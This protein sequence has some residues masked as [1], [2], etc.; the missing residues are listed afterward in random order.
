MKAFNKDVVRTILSSKKRFFSIMA[1]C[2]L[3]VTM[4]VGLAVACIDLRKSA[5]AFFDGQGL[6]DLSVTSTLGLT[7]DDV[8]ALEALDG[9]EAAEGGY[10]A[11]VHTDIDG[12][13]EQADVK[14]LSDAGINEPYVLEGRLPQDATEVAVTQA[15]LND[16]GKQIGDTLTFTVDD[17]SQG[18]DGEGE[19]SDDEGTEP[20]FPDGATYTI[21]GAVVDPTNVISPE[22]ATS[23]RNS[24]TS[25]YVFYLVRDAASSDVYSV[26]YLRVSG[27][28]EPACYSGAY[29]G[30]VEAAQDEVVSIQA[31]RETARADE[32]R[33]D[34]LAQ[35]DDA[36]A[37]LD[38]EMSD[39]QAQ[40]DAGRQ[41]VADSRAALDAQ[42]ASYDYLP[43]DA[44]AQIDAGYAQI[45]QSEADLQASQDEL[46]ARRADAQADIDAARADAQVLEATWYIQ[47]R[48]SLVGYSS[49]DS[50]A[51][52]IETIAAVLPVIFLV[53]AV[54]VS[55]TTAMRM[56]EEQRGLIGIYKALG[57]SNARIMGKYAVYVLAASFIGSVL[58]DVVGFFALP[59]F[60]FGIFRTMYLLPTYDFA[61]DAVYAIGG[62]ALFVVAIVGATLVACRR[63]LRQTP[64]E[65]MR[66]KAPKAGKR[67]LLERVGP[68]WR[69]MSFLNKVTARNLFRYKARFFMTVF[70][71]LGCTMLLVCGFA[72]KNTVDSLP[73]R[74]YDGVYGYDLMAVTLADDLAS[75]R[76]DLEGRG[77]V[78]GLMELSVDNATLVNGADRSSMQ[79]YVVPEGSSLEGYVVLEDAAGKPIELP[80]SGIVVTD[81]AAKILGFSQGDEVVLRTS[82]L[83]EE[84]LTVEAVAVNY[85]GNAVYMSQDAYEQAFGAQYEP[86]ALLVQLSGDTDAQVAF[87]DDLAADDT[88][89][90]VTS[91]EKMRGDFSSAFALINGIVYLVI[92]LAAGLAFV[93][94]F[95]LST[96]NI[97]E[98]ERELATLKVL[99]F[100]RGEVRRYVN[101]E[102]TVLTL[103]GVVL[104]LPAGWLLSY[105]FK[106]LLKLPA[107]SFAT[108]V[109]PWTYLI[110]TG[111]TLVFAFLVSL[112]TNRMLD[113]IDMV[114]ALKSP[115]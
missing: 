96:T 46:D 87:A 103:L 30:L 93:V 23:L 33:T 59:E 98:R 90:S 92:V 73:A 67:I 72:I 34:A 70:G 82:A 64:A 101:K 107:I 16:S 15:Y 99:G 51:T 91:I 38:A 52:S 35:V 94:L 69:R 37:T 56:V 7:D 81:N 71:I 3:G 68:L 53:V 22:G 29:E 17:T 49:V 115:E 108:Y 18:A 43:D 41:Q 14:A 45:S 39:A 111:I 28:A 5:D 58:G 60:L 95:T 114:E 32:V 112:V 65:L 55:L 47:N 63:D 36:Q 109:S 74:Q 85:L 11:S 1:I 4:L 97:S 26:V 113:R 80:E 57:Y 25:D 100:R 75:A 66:P 104:G 12:H 86:N 89:L 27:A 62:V 48:M 110:A 83:D 76:T 9:I 24:T 10:E 84:A 77:E 8:A 61:F 106:F 42:A 20:M 31:E 54:L 102:T 88:Y 50:D 13:L 19:G 2:A 78:V 6:F 105:S 79:L 21:V 44:K 40:I